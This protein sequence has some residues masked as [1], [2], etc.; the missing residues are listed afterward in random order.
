MNFLYFLLDNAAL[1]A[2]T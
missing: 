2:E 1:T